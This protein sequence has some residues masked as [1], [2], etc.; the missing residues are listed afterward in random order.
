MSLL[1]MTERLLTD[2]TM[3]QSGRG[4]PTASHDG[5]AT[6]GPFYGPAT[7][8]TGDIR[9]PPVSGHP[10]S[11]IAASLGSDSNPG[12]FELAI[13]DCPECGDR[14]STISPQCPKCG[15]VF[16]EAANAIPPGGE[17]PAASVPPSALPPA[18][19]RPRSQSNWLVGITVVAVVGLIAAGIAAAVILAGSV[20]I[21]S[22][23]EDSNEVEGNADTTIVTVA[24]DTYGLLV[25]ECI[26]DDELEHYFAGAD[27]TTTPCAGPHDNEV[28]H[29]HEFAAGPYPGED[30]ASAD[31]AAVCEDEFAAYVGRDYES[32]TLVIYRLWPGR[33]LWD[34]GGR[35]GECLLYRR[36]LE[37]LTGSAY[38]SGW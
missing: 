26:D 38:Q 29:V 27:Y 31:L 24:A 16:S 32:S 10:Q 36:D 23:F 12:G 30:A 20:S 35:T 6:L 14:I 7:P 3:L 9:Y 37:A 11:C 21:T 8:S 28:Y 5:A 4:C 22:P 1:L 34:S 2:A 19:A 15:H 25:G 18:N 13:V 33:E 17:T